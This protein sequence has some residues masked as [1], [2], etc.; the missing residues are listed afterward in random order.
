M[1]LSLVYFSA[2]GGTA[3]IV[4]GVAAGFGNNYKEFNITL[5]A[6][7]EKGITFNPNDLV[8]VGLPVYTVKIPKFL[9]YFLLV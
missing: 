9:I 7:R 4:K 8:I 2:T 3:K 5:P 1:Q 6:N